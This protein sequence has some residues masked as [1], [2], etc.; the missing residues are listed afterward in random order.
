[1]T[2]NNENGKNR[3][4][5]VVLDFG[6]QVAELIA[7]RCRRAGAF[8]VVVPFNALLKKILEHKPI[9]LILSG[10]PDSVYEKNA[11]QLDPAILKLGIPI[12]AICYSH[13]LLAKMLGGEVGLGKQGEYG[14]QEVTA[15]NYE[16]TPLWELGEK[17]ITWMS[18]GDQVTVLPDGFEVIGRTETCPIAAMINRKKGMVSFQFH[19]E[20]EHTPQGQRIIDY[21]LGKMC[22]ATRDWTTSSFKQ[23]AIQKIR[24]QVGNGYVI[25]GVSGGVDST[26]MA[27]LMSSAI[28]DRFIGVFVDNGLLRENEKVEVSAYLRKAGVQVIVVNAADLFLSRLTGVVDPERKRKI[29]GA[30][31]IEVFESEARLI[32]RARGIKIK[33]LAQ[34]TLYPDVIESVS[35]HGGPTAKIKSHHNVGGLPKKMGFQLVEPFRE[36][37]KDEVREL[38]G[39]LGLPKKI[40][41]RHPFP[42]PGLAIRIIGE[43]TCQKLKILR[44]ADAI[45]IKALRRSRK[46]YKVAQAFA[47]LT[48]SRSV[49]VVGDGRAYDYVVALRSVDTT[50][51]MTAEPS[52]LGH[53]FVCRVGDRI[54]NEVEGVG[55]VVEDKT[56]KPPGTIEWE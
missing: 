15:L 14:R 42:G 29:I 31:F 25:G 26:T 1:M 39:E 49:G 32:K 2:T 20:V 22:G 51:F 23:R 4:T 28:G 55:R 12:M 41:W 8:S 44:Q 45:F 13:Q 54:I 38:A 50:V 5:V 34:G 56:S 3:N 19:P 53:K 48:S 9:G 7:N 52:N 46:Y 36:I 27:V 17:I 18:H 11:P 21:F 43:I 40:Q 35:A 16:G 47:V 10:G 30:T 24:R 37:F 33:F 6:S